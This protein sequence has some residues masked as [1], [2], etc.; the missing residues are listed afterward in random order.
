MLTYSYPYPY[1]YSYPYYR[2]VQLCRYAYARHQ[3]V[4]PEAH[5]PC[6]G[7][8]QHNSRRM[9]DSLGSSRDATGKNQPICPTTM[10]CMPVSYKAC[11]IN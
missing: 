8:T 2:T 10:R 5:A 7:K 6:P 3:E 11:F 1:P 4:P 9:G